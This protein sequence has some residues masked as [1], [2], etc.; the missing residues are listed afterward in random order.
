MSRSRTDALRRGIE[1]AFP[2]RPFTIELWDGSRIPSTRPGPTITVRSSQAIGHF[3]R[4]PGEL[5]LGRAYVCGEIDVD[6]LDGII[7]LLGRWHPP[8]LG[9]GARLRFG[10]AAL[11]AFGL[12]RLPSPPAAELR[13]GGR[14]HTKTR[15]AEAVR[16]HYD[17]S[18]E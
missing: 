7:S 17:V 15:D 2:D 16:H 1:R 6:D 5:G 10:A 14:R 11:R 3:L 18:N 9:L 4:A 13:P 12:S 8:P